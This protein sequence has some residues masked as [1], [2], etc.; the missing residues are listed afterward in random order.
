MHACT[1]LCLLLTAGEKI[2]ALMLM[3]SAR[4]RACVHVLQT[5]TVIQDNCHRPG[6]MQEL[7]I[8]IK[9]KSDKLTRLT[10][11]TCLTPQ[12]WE[13]SDITRPA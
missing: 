2:L 9:P 12:A 11:K 8:L 1:R 7:V 6:V 4:V 3:A 13:L 5:A 10:N